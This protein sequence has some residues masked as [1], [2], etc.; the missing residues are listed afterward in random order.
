MGAVSGKNRAKKGDS[1]HFLRAT[2]FCGRPRGRPRGSP[3][4]KHRSNIVTRG[5]HM[6][7]VGATLVVARCHRVAPH[8]GHPRYLHERI[9]SLRGWPL[10]ATIRGRPQGRPQGGDHKGDHKGRPYVN[11]GATLQLTVNTHRHCWGDHCGRL[12]MVPHIWSPAYGP[13]TSWLL[14]YGLKIRLEK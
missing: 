3:L 6:R 4:R 14:Y 8:R 13:P 1:D 9:R 5:E 7:I 2:T 10:G 11:T 12:Q